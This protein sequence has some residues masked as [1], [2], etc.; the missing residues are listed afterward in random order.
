MLSYRPPGI[1]ERAGRT[2]AYSL[3]SSRRRTLTDRKPPP[4]GVVRG[5]LSA[6]RVRRML[7]SSGA[8]S[9]APLAAIAA[10][11]P[12]WTSHANGDPNAARIATTAS[13][14]SGPM[15]SPGISVAAIGLAFEVVISVPGEKARD[16]N[17][18]YRFA[19]RRLYS[20][21]G[22]RRGMHS[23]AGDRTFASPDSAVD[24]VRHR[25]GA[26]SCP[27]TLRATRGNA[28]RHAAF[29]MARVCRTPPGRSA[30]VPPGSNYARTQVAL[31]S[32]IPTARSAAIE[33][34]VAPWPA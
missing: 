2:F 13:V 5:P 20:A 9:G 1:S 12:C 31:D 18:Q 23:C 28:V 21:T 27:E 7:S 3:N 30:V 29:P 6:R 22:Q 15:P 25:F 26:H 34:I 16:G 14:I 4:T 24:A 17:G 19:S 10:I 33:F 8:G 32:P 11:P